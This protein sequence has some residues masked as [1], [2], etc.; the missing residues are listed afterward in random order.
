MHDRKV[1]DRWKGICVAR[2]VVHFSMFLFFFRNLIILIFLFYYL[3]LRVVVVSAFPSAVLL[4]ADDFSG[5]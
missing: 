5:I 3:L 2:L 4:V 1:G